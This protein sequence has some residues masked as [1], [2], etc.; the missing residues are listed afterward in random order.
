MFNITEPTWLILTDGH[1][2]VHFVDNEAGQHTESWQ[3][4]LLTSQ[5]KDALIQMFFDTYEEPEDG[6][7][8]YVMHPFQW[9]IGY[10]QQQA[11]QVIDLVAGCN[12]FVRINY[13]K[14]LGRD[15]YAVPVQ[16][17][18]FAALPESAAKDMLVAAAE[19]SIAAGR[20]R[21]TAQMK[22]EGWF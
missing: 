5:D 20:R 8:T 12:D 14:H 3:P 16:D 13:V 22:A 17:R 21:T 9:S 18:V 6:V 19:Q 1:D 11:Q 2:V 4:M 10:T 7:P 15:E